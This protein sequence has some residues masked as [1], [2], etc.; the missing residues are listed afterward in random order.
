MRTSHLFS[1]VPLFLFAVGLGF[2]GC[3]DQEPA[4]VAS[5]QPETSAND[6][7]QELRAELAQLEHIASMPDRGTSYWV[8]D[9]PGINRP[10]SIVELP[11]GSIDGLA[12]ALASAGN[13]GTV[14][15]RAG[16]HTESGMA[17][18]SER[19]RLIGEPGAIMMFDTPPDPTGYDVHP[20]IRVLASHVTIWG[21]EIRPPGSAGGTAILLKNSQHALIANNTFRDQ[22][23]GVF[24]DGGDKSMVWGNT[25]V[26]APTTTDPMGIVNCNGKQVH[27]AGN[28]V[29]NA[30]FGIWACDENGV[31][32]GNNVHANL[33]GIIL[34]KVPANAYTLPGNE[35]V[36]SDAPGAGWVVTGNQ[37]TGNFWGYLVIDSANRNLL[38]NNAASNSIV[39]DVELTADTF[40]FGFLTPASYDNRFIA[41]SNPNIVVKNCGNNNTIVGGQLVNNT[42]DPCF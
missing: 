26:C 10:T 12:A 14:L 5:P 22:H 11:A 7:S 29:T 9:A 3:S 19:V 35:T 37:A 20:A 2:L 1:V 21:L 17:T 30:L 28:N 18:I 40:R 33:I 42:T 36:G 31:L 38:T 13:N 16:T 23:L 34:C 25:I 24:V 8:S 41:G 39:Y 32:V 27:I 6:I 15:I 4:P